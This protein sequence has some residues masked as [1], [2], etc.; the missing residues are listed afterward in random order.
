MY[1]KGNKLTLQNVKSTLQNVKI[2]LQI[3]YLTGCVLRSTVRLCTVCPK[4]SDPFY[5]V[6]YY[7]KW[8]TSWILYGEGGG[9]LQIVFEGS[10]M[11]IDIMASK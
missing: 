3:T 7:I 5:I 4:S 9:W 11:E 6:S 10:D 1:C 2:M 8:V